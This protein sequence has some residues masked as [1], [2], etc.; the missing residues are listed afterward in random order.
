ML[1]VVA[2][3][4]LS[5]SFT[6]YPAL[7]DRGFVKPRTIEIAPRVEM[8]TDRGPIV[9]IVVRCPSGTAIISY[10]KVERLYCSPKH[11]CDKALAS[12]VARSCS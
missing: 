12:V 9:E 10:S 4:V 1:G 5:A 8:T 2:A 11:K 7:G 6:S 3:S